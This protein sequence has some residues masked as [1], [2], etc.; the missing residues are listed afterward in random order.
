MNAPRRLF[1]AVGLSL[2]AH[3]SL[4]AI[5]PRM[6]MLSQVPAPPPMTVRILPQEAP[7]IVASAPPVEAP[8][9][10]PRPPTPVTRPPRKADRVVPPAPPQPQEPVPAPE[11]VVEPPGAVVPPPL[12]ML[13]MIESR[14]ERRRAMEDARRTPPPPV[15]QQPD[16]ASRNLQT[17]TGR[18]GVSGVF[19][20]L[21]MGTRTGSFAFNGW[22][23]DAR[24]QWREVFEVDAGLG[25]NLELAMVRK[26]IQL[27]RGHY[28][29]D[30]NWESYRLGR[31]VVLSARAEQQQELEDFLLREF[32]GQ[33]VVNPR[34]ARPQ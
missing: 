24:G 14:R 18:D 4:L 1:L 33:Q 34:A 12:D 22:R 20:I 5:H 2:L 9:P 23:R 3:A 10:A 6:P 17:L 29:G 11:P 13:A 7:D 16:A 30:F 28:T 32:F 19:A 8:Q 26:M 27:I 21:S 31:V 15:P 25:G